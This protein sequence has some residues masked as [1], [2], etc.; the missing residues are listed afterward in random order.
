MADPKAPAKGAD[1]DNSG[2][3]SEKELNAVTG[4]PAEA[5]ETD[6]ASTQERKAG[7][8]SGLAAT[9]EARQQL[10]D[11]SKPR[12]VAIG[13]LR[14]DT[15]ILASSEDAEEINGIAAAAVS[16][17]RA[18][19]VFIFVAE[20]YFSESTVDFVEPDVVRYGGRRFDE[21]EARLPLLNP[22]TGEQSAD[23]GKS[24]PGDAAEAPASADQHAKK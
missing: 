18:A 14:R 19:E 15:M 23:V 22:G 5:S 3:V 24:D 2:K 11:Q 17:G 10:I 6:A 9:A 12:L 20:G 8:A 4:K 7:D 1:T 16:E 13:R 21:G